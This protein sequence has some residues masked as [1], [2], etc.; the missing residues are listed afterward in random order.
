MYA[1]SFVYGYKNT[2]VNRVLTGL[3]FGVRGSVLAVCP[4]HLTRTSRAV[5]RPR[6]PITGA[7]PT[8]SCADRTNVHSTHGHLEDCLSVTTR[9]ERSPHLPSQ[10]VSLRTKKFQ[11]AKLEWDC[12]FFA[13]EGPT[14][15]STTSTSAA[16]R[17]IPVHAGAQAAGLEQRKNNYSY[18]YS[19]A[20]VGTYRYVSVPLLRSTLFP[21][22]LH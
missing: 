18:L 13:L 19:S 12:M 2:A 22:F 9:D 14:S 3:E 5:S 1:F 21:S 11:T 20:Q 17:C 4:P 6:T 15:T 7:G 10:R 8:V 16:S